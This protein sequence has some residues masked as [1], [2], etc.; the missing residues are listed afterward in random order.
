MKHRFTTTVTVL[1]ET[2]DGDGDKDTPVGLKAL[3]R[4][5]SDLVVLDMNDEEE[6]T[7]FGRDNACQVAG[8]AINWNA[9]APAKA[10]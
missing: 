5:L 3:A 1:V 7:T 6:G 4:K 8:V 2:E 10:S 9:L